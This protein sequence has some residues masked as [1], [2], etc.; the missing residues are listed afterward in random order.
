MITRGEEILLPPSANWYFSC[1]SACSRDGQYYAYAAGNYIV[2]IDPI[3]KKFVN[4][5][6]H[7]TKRVSGLC[8]TDSGTLLS[9]GVDRALKIWNMSCAHPLKSYNKRPAEITAMVVLNSFSECAVVG[10][11]SGKLSLWTVEFESK[12][13][14][15]QTKMAS[16]VMSMAASPYPAA[17]HVAVGC[18]DGMVAI[19]DVEADALLNILQCKT[20]YHIQTLSWVLPPRQLTR[21]KRRKQNP[22]DA[23]AMEVEPEQH[24]PGI[25]DAPSECMPGGSNR[26]ESPHCEMESRSFSGMNGV[27]GSEDHVTVSLSVVLDE[28]GERVQCELAVDSI[29]REENGLDM[30]NSVDGVDLGADLEE[31]LSVKEAVIVAGCQDGGIRIWKTG[32]SGDPPKVDYVDLIQTLHIKKPSLATTEEQQKKLWVCARVVPFPCGVPASSHHFWVLGSGHMGELMAWI[33]PM[34]KGPILGKRVQ[35]ATHHHRN[36]FTIDFIRKTADQGFVMVTNSLDRNL[37][38][39]EVD[40]PGATS[41]LHDT[42]WRAMKLT[43]C[44]AG[45]GAD[46][47]SMQLKPGAECVA[48]GCAD[49]T[50][51]IVPTVNS[52]KTKIGLVRWRGITD[53]V[54][55]V[56]WH[57]YAADLLAFGCD[58]GTVGLMKVASEDVYAYSI[59][60]KT[61]VKHAQW[62]SCVRADGELSADLFTLGQEGCLLEW[63]EAPDECLR[64][65]TEERKK[66][67]REPKCL[68]DHPV[69]MSRKLQGLPGGQRMMWCDFSWDI[70]GTF[71]ALGATNGQIVIYME[72]GQGNL[73]MQCSAQHYLSPIK[74]IRWKLPKDASP[75]I[76]ALHNDGRFG[77]HEIGIGEKDGTQCMVL[78]S[79][80]KIVSDRAQVINWGISEAN[81]LYGVTKQGRGITSLRAWDVKDMN[82]ARFSRTI[83]GCVEDFVFSDNDTMIA[84]RDYNCVTRIHIP[85]MPL[86]GIRG[87]RGGARARAKNEQE[88]NRAEKLAE[89]DIGNTVTAAP[90]PKGAEEQIALSDAGLRLENDGSVDGMSGGGVFRGEGLN[91]DVMDDIPDNLMALPTRDHEA[92]EMK[93]EDG[94]VAETS[95]GVTIR[96][97]DREGETDTGR[98]NEG[99][100]NRP[101]TANQDDLME[102]VGSGHHVDTQA[103]RMPVAS[104]LKPESVSEQMLV[105]PTQKPAAFPKE[106]TKG[107]LASMEMII[108]PPPPPPPLPPTKVIGDVVANA[109]G[110]LGAPSS[111]ADRANGEVVLQQNGSPSV[112]PEVPEA[113][114]SG[115]KHAIMKE[116]AAKT[117]G[118]KPSAALK[119]RVAGRKRKVSMLGSASLMESLEEGNDEKEQEALCMELAQNLFLQQEQPA[120][121]LSALGFFPSHVEAS[122][123]LQETAQMIED[124]TD[125]K[126]A[127]R[128]AALYFWQG[129]VQDALDALKEGNRLDGDFLSMAVAGGV[130]VWASAVQTRAEYLESIGE[131]HLAA[132]HF[133][134]VGATKAAIAVYRRAGL[135]E[136]AFRLGSVRLMKKDPLLEELRAEKAELDARNSKFFA[137]AAGFLAAGKTAE[138]IQILIDQGSPQAW[139]TAAKIVKKY[140][141]ANTDGEIPGCSTE[142]AERALVRFGLQ[143]E[144]AI[145]EEVLDAWKDRNLLCAGIVSLVVTSKEASMFEVRGV[146][147]ESGQ[148]PAVGDVLRAV[149]VVVPLWAKT[150]EAVLGNGTDVET[151]KRLGEEVMA[152]LRNLGNLESVKNEVRCQRAKLLCECY[153]H[154][155]SGQTDAALQT[156]S[157]WGDLALEDPPVEAAAP[158]VE[159]RDQQDIQSSSNGRMENANIMDR[160]AVET[161]QD[162]GSGRRQYRSTKEK[163]MQLETNGEEDRLKFD[164]AG[165]PLSHCS[166]KMDT[167]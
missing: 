140:R 27:G 118:G 85:S 125:S 124:P 66:S 26:S 156:L 4:K 132:L 46:I 138:A 134:S 144:A 76:A 58:D 8:I 9:G 72:L 60:H 41:Q 3:N 50:V 88:A 62:K 116:P 24:I 106:E 63:P 123:S 158:D 167:S 112:I 75:M 89:S 115:E 6:D 142:K 157:N 21:P 101:I 35:L 20:N 42:D 119:G 131:I 133:L 84:S 98:E 56:A 81:V 143:G 14:V 77:V 54:T 161:R 152:H 43:W 147:P 34:H 40:R 23:D 82:S 12:P 135:A 55:S 153:L 28:S 48:L 117:A 78:N 122:A 39:W 166:D 111:S 127:E 59:R 87:Q 25:T 74:S 33:V 31:E 30:D 70:S 121:G 79:V 97:G 2:V 86:P 141:A 151:V 130:D 32:V 163:V 94:G 148:E 159:M 96:A 145:I 154:H 128:K 5:L 107:G 69:D 19:V 7:H 149:G 162:G 38:V 13:K 52:G 29:K 11:K 67:N 10:D 137:A 45:V 61:A 83:Q 53:R 37:I 18:E 150:L 108:P 99:M 15:L 146:G 136:D 164:N 47:L 1:V 92:T 126:S 57:P 113:S 93:G 160:A 51:R 64:P 49:K 103:G 109:N 120:A 114:G 155:S 16:S 71:L 100:D 22:A 80:C 68:S 90:E 95:G 139:Q 44:F 129:A 36:V 165:M 110:T 65:R 104:A 91:D 102:A 73:S 17:S 105:A